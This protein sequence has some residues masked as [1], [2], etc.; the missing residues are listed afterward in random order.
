MS[1]LEQLYD[2]LD[3]RLYAFRGKTTDFWEE[4]WHGPH[5]VQIFIYSPYTGPVMGHVWL[6]HL[7]DGTITLWSDWYPT[8]A[9]EDKRQVSLTAR[10]QVAIRLEMPIAVWVADWVAQP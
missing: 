1:P 10:D 5:N 9:A 8:Y 3:T 7:R 2:E 4:E 6:H